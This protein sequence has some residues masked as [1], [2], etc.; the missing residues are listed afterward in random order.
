MNIF[1]R[2]L[3]GIF[4]D[5]VNKT[6]GL[7]GRT[8]ILGFFLFCAGLGIILFSQMTSLVLAISTLILFAFFVKMSNGAT[9]SVVP[10]MNK[11]SVGMVAGI[12]GAGGNVGAM[13]M[14]FVLKME[15]VTYQTGLMYIGITV[16]LVSLLAFFIVPS[17]SPSS[18][19]KSPNE[20][21]IPFVRK[22]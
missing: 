8:W 10:F 12:V 1:A 20:R 18:C 14:G 9:Y 15:G 16:S 2:A 4:S 17:L 7:K 6:Y 19:P 21:D 3:G 22:P 11:K 5:K 13:L